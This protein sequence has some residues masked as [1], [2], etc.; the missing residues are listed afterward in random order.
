MI[1]PRHPA[2]GLRLLLLLLGSISVLHAQPAPRLESLSATAVQRGTGRR[3]VLRGEA[4][5]DGGGILMSAEDVNARVEAPPPPPVTLESPG[6]NLTAVGP[7][8]DRERIVW[9]GVGSDAPPGPRELRWAGPNG[10]SNPLVIQVGD[11]PELDEPDGAS[12]PDTAPLLTLPA[13]VSGTIGANAE[14]DHY[15]IPT[16]PGQTIV[17]DLQAN[18]TGSPLD[19]TLVV[20]DP[21]GREIARSEDHHG[22]DPFVVFSPAV[23]GIHQ[24]RLHDVRHQG[25][26]AYRYRLA[27]GTIPHLESV[28]PLGGQRGARVALE[29]AGHNLHESTRMTVLVDPDFT[30]GRQEIRARTPLG[31]SNPVG[32]AVDDLPS[33]PEKEPND[34]RAQAQEVP[35]PTA[36]D[37][38]I[39]TVGDVDTFAFKPGASGPWVLEVQARRLGSP[40]DALL[41]LR[42]AEGKVLQRN[43]DAGGQPD[44]RIGFEAV[45]GTTYQ[46]DIRDLV[47]RG[48]PRHG[49]RLS[50][51]PAERTP[52]FTVRAGEARL[53][54]HRLGRVAVRCEI[55]RRHGFDGIVRVTAEG[56]PAG[57]GAGTLVLAPGAGHGWLVLGADRSAVSGNFPLHL[58]ATGE[59]GGRPLRHPVQ[60]GEQSWLT[61][62]DDAPFTVDVAQST[63]LV[64]QNGSASLDVSVSRHGGFAGEVTLRADAPPGLAVPEVKL[65]PDFARGVLRIQ[66]THNAGTGVHPLLV[67]AEATPAGGPVHQAAPAPL[68]VTIQPIPLF[69]TAMLPGSPFFRTDTFR[70]SAAALPAGAES[71]ANTTEFVVKVDRRGYAGEVALILEG[72][73]AGVRADVPPVPS[74]RNEATIRLEIGPDAEVD[75]EHTLHVLGTIAHQDRTWR[76]KSQAVTLQITAP[77]RIADSPDASADPAP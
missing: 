18:R 64:E 70:L 36:V 49:Y 72:L 76:Q 11:V 57:V 54:V 52:G 65:G 41:T 34:T 56:L 21:D 13:A 75:R 37:G 58:V 3:V 44:P 50:L 1:P 24:V 26:T 68:P 8:T 12:N 20:L 33:T 16:R 55:D 35:V 4:L 51:H 7:A 2:A 6:G 39:G 31:Y 42:D 53:R 69:L 46:V 17:L 30:G 66:A 45:A 40:L 60:S 73:P 19:A 74:D 23:P 77:G 25:G 71:A 27:A 22:L 67:R 5:L 48:S 47:E 62:L 14:T 61:V 29:L 28:F 38:R 10:V 15:L 59:Q 43:D 63:V 32:F 9:I